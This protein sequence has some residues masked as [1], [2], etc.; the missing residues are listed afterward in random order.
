MSSKGFGL[1]NL[2]SDMK[3]AISISDLLVAA[4]LHHG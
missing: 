4:V 1:W 2:S 3:A